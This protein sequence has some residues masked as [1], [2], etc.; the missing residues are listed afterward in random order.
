MIPGPEGWKTAT[1]QGVTPD[2]IQFR[3]S[4]KHQDLEVI[5]KNSLPVYL[6]AP[7]ENKPASPT[8]PLS[9]A[10]LLQDCCC[11]LLSFLFLV[12]SPPSPLYF[13]SSL[14]SSPNV[15]LFFSFLSPF[16]PLFKFP[17]FC[18]PT[19]LSFPLY[20]LFILYLLALLSF[21]LIYFPPSFSP[22]FSFFLSL[23]FPLVFSSPPS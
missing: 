8:F 23:S 2:D 3:W 15:S 21:P 13:P 18:F 19:F 9:A 17:P 11:H 7:G 16:S 6:Y 12:S 5:S 20:L 22:V 14:V 4:P 10:S 1:V